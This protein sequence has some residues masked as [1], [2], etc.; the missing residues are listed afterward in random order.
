MRPQGPITLDIENSL[1]PC[2]SSPHAISLPAQKQDHFSAQFHGLL[3]RDLDAIEIKCQHFDSAPDFG[4]LEL[5]IDLELPYRDRQALLIGVSTGGKTAFG[6]TLG[7]LDEGPLHHDLG[8]GTHLFEAAV[9]R[10]VDARHHHSRTGLRCG[11]LRRFGLHLATPCKRS[12]AHHREA[13]HD[14][15]ITHF[16]SSPQ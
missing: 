15:P 16:P 14:H 4:A 1:V 7:E 12:R 10:V 13:G 5:L 8:P 9:H 2:C 6:V 11:G 3:I